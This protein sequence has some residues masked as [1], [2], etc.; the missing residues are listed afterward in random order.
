M[1]RSWRFTDIEFVV[2][3]SDIAESLPEPF[4]YTVRTADGMKYDAQQVKAREDLR[5]RLDPGFAEVLQVVA[6]PDLR[7]TARA[8]DGADWRRTDRLTRVLG[9]RRE[10][11]G[12][13]I[14]QLPGET[15]W[16]S[17]DFIVT[18]CAALELGDRIV[19]ALPEA[20]PGRLP[21]TVLP[22]RTEEEMDYSFVRSQVLDSFQDSNVERSRYLRETAAERVGAIEIIQ[23]QSAYGPR[24]RTEHELE[25]RDLVDDGRYVI[26][27]QNPP[28]AI[29]ADAKRL[30]TMV[31]NRIAAVVRAIKDE[32][33]RANT[34]FGQQ[35]WGVQRTG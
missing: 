30:T 19:A 29:G 3:L 12:Y 5:R 27:D 11:R 31:N 14:T 21:D 7:V 25:L 35:D 34:D 4:Y 18:E 20:E 28:V 1:S 22:S 9:V 8:W 33:G 2:L 32:E 6:R 13:L 26:D 24:G 23:G 16:H 10:D 15:F 17:G